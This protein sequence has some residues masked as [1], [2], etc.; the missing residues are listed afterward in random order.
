MEPVPVIPAAEPVRLQVPRLGMD[1]E[2][3]KL[4]RANANPI[5]P[6]TML[7]AYWDTDFGRPGTDATDITVVAAHSWNDGEAAFNGLLDT[8]NGRPLVTPGDKTLVTTKNGV[9]S[10]IVERVDLYRKG[11]L[12]QADFWDVMD[13][14]LLVLITCFYT[15]EGVSSDNMVVIARLQ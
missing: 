13:G 12:S 15:A 10:Y 4:P 2:V 6:P 7:E 9:L 5:T 3:R 11:S 14:R 8:R 1:L